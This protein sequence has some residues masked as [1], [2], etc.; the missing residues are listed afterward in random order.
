VVIDGYQ[1]FQHARDPYLEVLLERGRDLAVTVVLLVANAADV[2]SR[3]GA[4]VRVARDGTCTYRESGAAGR[5]IA[6]VVADELDVASAASLARTLAPL[7]LADAD[8]AADLVDTVRLVELLG[9]ES[10]DQIDPAVDWLRPPDLLEAA[11]P[12]AEVGPA[13]P[14]TRLGPEDLLSIPI[15]VRSDGAVLRLDLKEAAAGGMGPH[16]MLIGAT[17]SGKSELLRSLVIGLAARHHPDLLNVVLVDFKGGAAFADLDELPHTAGLITNLENDPSLIDRMRAS[18]AGEIDRRQQ[19]LRDAGKESIRAYHDEYAGDPS[20]P[21]LPYLLVVVDEFGGLLAARPEFL[22]VFVQI[23]Q[24][25][26]SLGVHLL[27]A[28]QRLDEGRIRNLDSHLRY[29]ICLRTYSAAES[30][31][32]IGVPDAYALPPMPGLGYIRADSD[33]VRFKAATTMLPHRS[34]RRAGPA[35]ATVRPFVA[36]RAVE[37]AVDEPLEGH[38]EGE[39]GAG[40]AEMQVLVERCR[41][42]VAAARQ[43]WLPPLPSRLS[44]AELRDDGAAG[45]PGSGVQADVG[46]LDDPG[47]QSQQPL[48][49]DLT[50]AGGHVGCVG[51]PRT[52]KTTFLRTLVAGLATTRSPDDVSVYVVDLGGGL[53]DLGDLPHVGAVAGRHDP[54]AVARLLREMRAVVDERAA[55]FRELGVAGLEALRAHPRAQELLPDPLASDVLLVIDNLGVLRSEF[56]ELDLDLADLAATSLQVGVHVVV[57]ANRWL[58]VRPSLLDALGTRLE[59]HINDPVD[60]MAGRAAA[61]TVPGDRPGR[62]IIRDGRQFQ[63]AVADPPDVDELRRRWPTAAPR[64]MPLPRRLPV[65]AVPELASAAGRQVSAQEGF[66]L[67]AAEFRLAPV[68]LELLAPGQHLLVYGDEGSGRSTLVRRAVDHLTDRPQ[69]ELHIVDLGRG[70]LDVADAPGVTHYAFTAS[71]ADALAKDLVAELYDRLPPADLTR[72][73]LLDRSWWRGPEHVLVVDDFDLSISSNSSSLGILSDALGYARD[74][75]LHVV[76]ARQVAG[77]ART[78]YESFGQ[79]LRET[80]PTALL[81][82]GDRSEGPLVGDRP[83]T[84]Q[85]PGRGL[86]IRRGHQDTVVQLAVD[87]SDDEERG[88]R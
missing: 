55:A 75:G 24:L 1:P 34:V 46:R 71:L 48:R 50:G 47:R 11:R 54:E 23:G 14:D 69:V 62:G 53:H 87:G 35:P 76:L 85:P 84:R 49:L 17:G 61:S 74:I 70:L 27:L 8:A 36:A 59:L 72:D 82:S 66:L 32:V 9:H 52:G 28:S 22:D 77:S 39:P 13:E 16:G 26:R 78:S 81:L 58:D 15:G 7:A 5:Y 33:V 38:R 41:A 51:G 44:L 10:A 12:P 30:S 68:H 57:T 45:A 80:A 42:D 60:S 56:P 67:G 40:V 79:R 31:A 29:R 64:V 25:G 4:T 83:A 43:V 20:A 73:Q 37:P 63:L 88:P 2:P 86:L 3:C 6:E 21:S 19:L 65:E 18:L